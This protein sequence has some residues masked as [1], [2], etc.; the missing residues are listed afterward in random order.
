MFK[1]NFVAIVTPFMNGKCDFEAYARLV[2]WII[3]NGVDGIVVCGTTG[4][5]LTLSKVERSGLV[6]ET[7]NFVNKRVP[8]I[9][10]VASPSTREVIEQMDDVQKYDIDGIM[11]LCPFYIKPTQEGIFQHFKA[12]SENT[13]LPVIIYDNP[14]R[15]AVEI[16]VST[17]ERLMIFNNIV[18]IKEA[19]SDLT[20]FVL[21]RQ[22][23]KPGFSLLSGNDD[24]F[25]AA[26]NMGAVGVVSV[27]ANVAP[28]YCA[29]LYKCWVNKDM[30]GF[31]K[32]RDRLM[33][34]HRAMFCESN[35][36]PVKYALSLL[37]IIRNEIRA[38]LTTISSSNEQIIRRSMQNLGLI[39]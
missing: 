29:E 30:E 10:G 15:T 22:R 1:G 28:K 26:L 33:P 8:V 7:V 17:L 13:N 37:G 39:I 16:S 18:A 3:D 4:E 20:K 31:E 14:G 35:P 32:R 21:L 27:T 19:S 36:I 2:N 23:M 9:V 5:S 24:T 34:L 6:K 38:P 11:A 12:V 25:A